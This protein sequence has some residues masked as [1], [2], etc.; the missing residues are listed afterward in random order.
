MGLSYTLQA[1]RKRWPS[2]LL[3]WMGRSAWLLWLAVALDILASS[4]IQPSLAYIWRMNVKTSSCQ[5]WA[6]CAFFSTA[7]IK[8]SVFNTSRT[9]SKPSCAPRLRRLC[10]RLLLTLNHWLSDGGDS[11]HWGKMASF[12]LHFLTCCGQIFNIMPAPCDRHANQHRSKGPRSE[13]NEGG[14][15]LIMCC[16]R[17]CFILKI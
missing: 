15:K 14:C 17:T 10:L 2:Q 8:S 3:L 5:V 6:L 16:R 1:V 12:R 7:L 13:K 4:E 11:P 9:S